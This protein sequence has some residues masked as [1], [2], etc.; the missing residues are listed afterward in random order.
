MIQAVSYPQ[1]EQE[2]KSCKNVQPSKDLSK[3]PKMLTTIGYGQANSILNASCYYQIR[4]I[5]RISSILSILQ[6]PDQTLSD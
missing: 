6:I 4:P 5:G 1:N 2:I 3:I